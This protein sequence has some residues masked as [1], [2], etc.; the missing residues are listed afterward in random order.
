MQFCSQNTISD[1]IT[2]MFSKMKQEPSS[3]TN[4]IPEVLKLFSQII[5]AVNHVHHMGLIH[6][7]L[8]PSNCFLDEEGVV[9]IGD[10]GLSRELYEKE[11][12]NNINDIHSQD[13]SIDQASNKICC[14]HHQPQDITAGIGTRSYASPEQMNGS[15]YDASTDI[16]SLGVLLF[17]LCYP[18]NTAM[19]KYLVFNDLRHRIFPAQWNS[20]IAVTFP[21]LNSLLYAM[22]SPNACERPTSAKI[23]DVITNLLNEHTIQSF[24]HSLNS[25]RSRSNSLSNSNHNRKTSSYNDNGNRNSDYNEGDNNRESSLLRTEAAD[26]DENDTTKNQEG[27]VM[28]RELLR[29][30]QDSINGKG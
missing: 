16:Y 14:D 22:L 11:N 5:N 29:F 25:R 28:Q 17:E 12:P 13:S 4:N 23:N 10:F 21:S 15:D 27:I 18:L 7:D 2:S 20:T 9:K 24:N 26:E 30:Y 19:E 6:R 1:W 3:S 8:K